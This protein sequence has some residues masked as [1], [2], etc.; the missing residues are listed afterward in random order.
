MDKGKIAVAVGAAGAG[1]ALLVR[2]FLKKDQENW[3]K[4]Q[5]EIDLLQS[6]GLEPADLAGKSLF[7]ATAKERRALFQQCELQSA[8]CPLCRKAHRRCEMAPARYAFTALDSRADPNSL[9]DLTHLPAGSEE[10]W[11]RRECRERTRCRML[12]ELPLEWETREKAKLLAFRE[13]AADL[14][15]PIWEQFLRGFGLDGGSPICPDCA[16]QLQSTLDERRQNWEQVETFPYT[17]RG[18]IPCDPDSAMLIVTKR[19]PLKQ[20]ALQELKEYAA[21]CGMDCVYAV[22]YRY[23]KT[24]TDDWKKVWIGAGKMARK[25]KPAE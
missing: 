9:A 19:H 5:E 14:P 1:A 18:K 7:A 25:R 16:K 17:Y 10:D 2:Q 24:S 15:G 20:E 3:E 12:A 23:E 22:E 6:M 11:Q 8:E 13:G 21:I 4:S